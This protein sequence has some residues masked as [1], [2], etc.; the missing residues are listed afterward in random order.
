[1]KK[2]TV[3]IIAMFAISLS[4]Q[5]ETRFGIA[6]GFTILN[7]QTEFNDIKTNDDDVSFYAGISLDFTA[8][9][10]LNIETQILYHQKTERISLP[11]FAKFRLNDNLKVIIGPQIYFNTKETVDDFSSVNFNA[12]GGF[13]YDV[14]DNFSIQTTYSYQINNS[15]TGSAD[16]SARINSFNIGY[17]FKF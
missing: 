2:I 8:S 3:L 7:S 12:M 13:S 6:T 4:A 11:V 9:K 14:D 15:Y 17:V 10:T 16:V 1:M 5:D